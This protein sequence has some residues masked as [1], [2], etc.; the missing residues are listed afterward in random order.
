MDE[1]RSNPSNALDIRILWI[2]VTF[3]VIGGL[4]MVGAGRILV[5]FFPKVLASWMAYLT[6]GVFLVLAVVY[7]V[8]KYNIWRYGLLENAVGLERGVII[9]IRTVVPLVRIQHVD[10]QRGPVERMTGLSRVVL[11]TA[12]SRGADVVIPGLARETAEDFQQNIKDLIAE[13]QNRWEDAV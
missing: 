8:L 2:W 12:G 6:G 7:V 4:F 13:D 11:Y 10:T 5:F 3:A 1:T 9:R